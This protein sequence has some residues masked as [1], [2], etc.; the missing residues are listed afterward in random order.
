MGLV[1]PEEMAENKINFVKSE[2]EYL[3]PNNQRAVQFSNFNFNYYFALEV[4]TS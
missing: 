1:K 3:F 2:T 4:A